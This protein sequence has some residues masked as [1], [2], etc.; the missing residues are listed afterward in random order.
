MCTQIL[1]TYTLG[2][3]TAG[4]GGP[5]V[6]TD[7]TYIYFGCSYSRY[8]WSICVHRF[9]IHILWV[10]LQ[11][12]LVVHMCT[13]V[14]HPLGCSYSTGIHG[15]VRTQISRVQLYNTDIGGPCMYTD[16][17]GAVTAQVLVV[18]AHTQISHMYLGC[19]YSS[20]LK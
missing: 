16:F 20:G 17:T 11:Q 9:Y 10:Q 5:F 6:Y 3:A 12:V 7:F 13:Q 14:L 2:A 15:H 19:S 4:I 1:H 8:W 18:H